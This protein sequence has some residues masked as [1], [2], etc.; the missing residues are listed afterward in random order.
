MKPLRSSPI[1]LCPLLW[2]AKGN[3]SVKQ[4]RGQE[5]AQGTVSSARTNCSY[6][7]AVP[8]SCATLQELLA[9]QNGAL[10]STDI[11]FSW[12]VFVPVANMVCDSLCAFLWRGEITVSDWPL[13]ANP[14]RESS[15]C[16]VGQKSLSSLWGPANPC[17]SGM[18]LLHGYV[19]C[20]GLTQPKF[21]I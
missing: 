18:C 15:L 19:W 8:V 14:E 4:P 10:F 16:G 13:C 6:K 3:W 5:D 7:C 17:A 1:F 9:S 11:Y 21:N 20:G 2:P 12:K